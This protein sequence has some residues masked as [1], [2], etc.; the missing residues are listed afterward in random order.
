[1]IDSAPKELV[2]QK[3]VSLFI[4]LSHGLRRVSV[5]N[6]GN[7]AVEIERSVYLNRYTITS[8]KTRLVEHLSLRNTIFRVRQGWLDQRLKPRFLPMNSFTERFTKR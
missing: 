8:K 3:Y 5:E 6:S 4:F 1:M 2:A 7:V